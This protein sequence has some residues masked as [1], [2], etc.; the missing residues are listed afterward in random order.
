MSRVPTTPLPPGSAGPP[1]APDPD[2][3]LW[4]LVAQLD[5][6]LGDEI[7]WAD[8]GPAMA[9]LLAH[10]LG[11]GAV[12][13]VLTAPDGGEWST[14]VAHRDAEHERLTQAL[15]ATAD[16]ADLGRAAEDLAAAGTGVHRGLPDSVGGWLADTFRRYVEQAGVRDVVFAPVVGGG[17]TV[18]SVACVRDRDSE[19]FS[20]ADV[21]AVAACAEKIGWLLANSSLRLLHERAARRW[22]SAFDTASI[23]MCMLDVDGRFTAVNPAACAI[24]GRPPEEIVGQLRTSF[25]HPDDADT[26][27]REM[28]RMRAGGEGIARMTRMMR[29]DGAIRWVRVFKVLVRDE[30]GRPQAFYAQYADMTEQYEAEERAARFEALAHSSPDFISIAGESGYLEYLNPAGRRLI[31]LPPD[32]D[33]TTLTGRDI[34]PPGTDLE[35][36]SSEVV[37]YRRDGQWQGR[38][39]LRDWRDGSEIPVLATTFV[40]KDIHTGAPI[41]RASQRRDIREQ[42]AAERVLAGLAEQQ[43]RL[44]EELVEAEQRERRRLAEDLH[45][46][47]V[48][49]LAAAQ[50]R[51]ELLSMQQ[52]NGDHEGAHRTATDVAGLI[53]DALLA[54]RTLLADLDPSEDLQVALPAA[55]DRSVQV[56]FG[57][58]NVQTSITGDLPGVDPVVAAVLHRSAR[59]ALSNAWRHARAE[60][61]DVRMR[62]EPDAWVVEVADDGIGLPDELPHRP[63]H[64]GL[65]AMASRVEALGG[66]VDIGRPAEGGTLVRLTVPRE[67]HYRPHQP[68][69]QPAS[70]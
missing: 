11:D 15:V 32:V 54:L 49:L 65:R 63:G 5:R 25:S 39:G 14:S 61:V 33:I 45:D 30:Q 9:R 66:R 50:L 40:I 69:A 38:A 28:D 56:L 68:A 18:G 10:E 59:E 29:P 42:V 70:A 31:G 27:R 34:L 67:D 23:G 3:R 7:D 48:Q 24:L 51:Q 4:R 62:V 60:H 21:H 47:A 13:S 35:S 58:S 36:P 26:D 55:L 53:T 64:L 43:R 16:D 46:D 44:L 1:G 57:R 41:A 19:P 37:S 17:L 52:A 12:V 20:D 6:F 22:Q 2:T 8:A